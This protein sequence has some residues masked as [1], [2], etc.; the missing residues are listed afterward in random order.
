MSHTARFSSW[1]RAAVAVLAL[2]WA[3]LGAAQVVGVPGCVQPGAGATC[4]YPNATTPTNCGGLGQPSCCCVCPLGGQSG[5]CTFPLA[6]PF[7]PLSFVGQPMFVNELPQPIFYQPDTTTYPGFEYYEIQAARVTTG[8]AAPVTPFGG[9]SLSAAAPMPDTFDLTGQAAKVWLGLTCPAGQVGCTANQKLYTEVWGYGQIATGNAV[10][11]L[12]NLV[13]YPAMSFKATKGTP[14]KVKWINNLPD[15][16][17]V[18]KQPLNSNVPCAIDRTIMGTLTREN[19]NVLTYGSPMQPDNAMVVHLHGGEIPP[20][21]DGLAEL[22]FGNST[23][24]GV[25]ANKF[26]LDTT[27]GYSQNVDPLFIAPAGNGILSPTRGPACNL[28]ALPPIPCP[29][30]WQICYGNTSATVPG[31][32]TTYNGNS[33]LT[34]DPAVTPDLLGSL[35]RPTG[36]AMIYNYPMVQN[37]ATIWYHDHAL[38]KTRINVVAGPAGYFYITDPAVEAGLN[39]PNLGDCSN[40]GILAGKCYDVPLVLQDRAF[41]P[42]GSINFPNGLGQIAPPKTPGWNPNAPGLNPFVHPQIVPEYFGDFAVVNGITWPKVTVEPRPYRF[43]LLDGSNARCYTLGLANLNP[44]LL[45]PLLVVIGSDQG[46][47]QNAAGLA[48]L[49]MCPGERFDVIID[50][51]AYAGQN[52]QLTNTA[53]APFPAGPTPQAAGSPFAGLASLVQFNVGT[54]CTGGCPGTYKVGKTYNNPA[55]WVPATL[56]SNS[57]RCPW[58]GVTTGLACQKILNEVADPTTAAPLRVQIDGKAFEDA[59]TET[60]KR[61]TTEV[62][63]IINTTVDAHPMHLHLVQFKVVSRQGFNVSSFKKAVGLPNNAFN[64]LPLTPVDV[65]PYLQG[66]AMLPTPEEAGF[67]DTAKSYPGEVLTLIAKWDGGWADSAAKGT[68]FYQAVT[69]G[70][71]VWH[72]HIVDHEDNE[73]MRPTLVMP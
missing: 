52:I 3:S 62:W 63:Q 23:T 33:T 28:L 67:K 8:L 5:T 22:W 36:N 60:P 45:A 2:A 42:D 73:M 58:N 56:T 14:V 39:L 13:T 20:D 69:S 38:G 40:G 15:Q 16:H 50:F 53:G 51:S 12:N 70:P 19:E 55:T 41:N 17:L 21:S 49:S 10:Y 37:A 64:R 59:I 34:G 1:A 46:Y 54:T 43:R 11:P 29:N 48:A 9:A 61:G 32:C 18:C 68:P 30:T 7:T 31:F 57:T 72:C 25:Y 24:A 47:L 27:Y 71:Y 4:K 65:A 66:A 35:I 6:A 44:K 26:P